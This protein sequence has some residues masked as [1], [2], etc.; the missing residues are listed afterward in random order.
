MKL[1]YLSSILINENAS[2]LSYAEKFVMFVLSAI[3]E[4]RSLFKLIHLFCV[5]ILL[6]RGY[7]PPARN[8]PYVDNPFGR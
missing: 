1:N 3:A 8:G 5:G 2:L 4:S 6:F 7:S